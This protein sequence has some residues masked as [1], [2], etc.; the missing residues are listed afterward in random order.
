MNRCYRC[1]NI[2]WFRRSPQARDWRLIGSGATGYLKLGCLDHCEHINK[3]NYSLSP[4]SFMNF[5]LNFF[6]ILSFYFIFLHHKVLRK[7]ENSKKNCRLPFSLQLEDFWDLF[8]YWYIPKNYKLFKI[9]S[10]CSKSIFKKI[11]KIFNLQNS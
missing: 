9:K 3:L 4:A 8:F 6:F 2:Y 7:L 10:K 1:W 11:F 5:N